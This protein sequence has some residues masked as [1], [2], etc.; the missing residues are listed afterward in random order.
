MLERYTPI[1][2]IIRNDSQEHQGA[3]EQFQTHVTGIGIRVLLGGEFT[4]PEVIIQEGVVSDELTAI[5]TGQ[6]TVDTAPIRELSNQE[7][8]NYWNQSQFIHYTKEDQYREY[9]TGMTNWISRTKNLERSDK[10]ALY[11]E[12]KRGLEALGI[13]IDTFH[14]KAYEEQRNQLRVMERSHID[15][16]K[17]RLLDS[18][19][20]DNGGAVSIPLLMQRLDAL[21][22]LLSCYG[23]ATHQLLRE[24]IIA[25]GHIHAE[26][27]NRV[28]F[29]QTAPTASNTLS[30]D[31]K[32]LL[33]RYYAIVK[34]QQKSPDMTPEQ[35]NQP[36]PSHPSAQTPHIIYAQPSSREHTYNDPSN[37]ADS[38][39]RLHVDEQPINNNS[40]GTPHTEKETTFYAQAE[41]DRT[42][43]KSAEERNQ[44]IVINDKDNIVMLPLEET[45]AVIVKAEK[46]IQSSHT[47]K[48]TFTDE[49]AQ[50]ILLF[51]RTIYEAQRNNQPIPQEVTEALNTL[52]SRLVIAINNNSYTPSDAVVRYFKAAEKVPLVH[53]DKEVTMQKEWG[54]S[55]SVGSESINGHKANRNEDRKLVL[56][57]KKIFGLFD[58]VGG[59]AAGEVAAEIACASSEKNLI[60]FPDEL[61]ETF[62]EDDAKRTMAEVLLE[63][64][65]DIVKR[66][67][68]DNKSMQTTASVVKILNNGLAIIGNVGDSRVYHLRNGK[69]ESITLDDAGIRSFYQDEQ[70]A[71]AVQKR[72]TN[73]KIPEDVPD[74]ERDFLMD[75]YKYGLE[76]VLGAVSLRT[77]VNEPPKPRIYTMQLL[78]G[79]ILLL[80]TDGIH[81]NATDEELEEWLTHNGSNPSEAAKFIA[82][83]SKEISK[84][85]YKARIGKPDYNGGPIKKKPDDGFTTIVVSIGQ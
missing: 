60:K 78:P 55:L 51:H 9:V 69:I 25:E 22:T 15:E 71:I 14:E 39:I 37:Q 28:L 26:N 13:D 50:D 31:D 32:N 35:E 68:A 16:V 7:G 33:T 19:R 10:H 66:S 41:Q 43:P 20:R 24:Q 70:T 76:Q 56:A 84:M 46:I 80:S 40:A 2:D 3:E 85:D 79:D 64:H 18:V 65:E 23:R 74:N 29:L 49:D 61:S 12:R 63:A 4:N 17:T 5:A 30:V 48:D 8:S 34:K 83:K 82:Q 62:S 57:D 45:D 72:V 36:T 54:G 11:E 1:P 38:S 6:R 53:G 27:N 77:K 47:N 81:D 75:D 67:L 59:S 42:D 21:H 44:D 52:W 58:G 73:A